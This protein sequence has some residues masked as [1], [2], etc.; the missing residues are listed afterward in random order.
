M[1]TARHVAIAMSLHRRVVMFGLQHCALHAA[2]MIMACGCVHHILMFES[3]D[4][5]CP[6]GG[7]HGPRGLSRPHVEDCPLAGSVGQRIVHGAGSGGM[8]HEG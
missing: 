6:R 4:A 2:V 8:A 1:V 5:G 3:I 7:W